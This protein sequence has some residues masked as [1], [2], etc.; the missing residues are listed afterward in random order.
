MDS[1]PQVSAPQKVDMVVELERLA[2]LCEKG[3]LTEEEFT[4]KKRVILGDIS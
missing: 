1:A 3:I 4:I 2:D